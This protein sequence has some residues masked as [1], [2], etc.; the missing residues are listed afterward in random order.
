MFWRNEWFIGIC[1][2]IISGLIVFFIQMVVTSKLGRKDYIKKVSYANEEILSLLK[3]V[4]SEDVYPSI[5]ILDSL[6]SSIS[7]RYN[8]KK[9][10][11]NSETDVLDDLIREVFDTSFMSI[12]KKILSANKIIDLKDQYTIR[13]TSREESPVLASKENLSNKASVESSFVLLTTLVA[14][15]LMGTFLIKDDSLFFGEEI[16]KLTSAMGIAIATLG[17]VL[18]AL[19]YVKSR[20]DEERLKRNIAKIREEQHTKIINKTE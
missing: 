3:S 12:D 13:E 16:T 17:I 11:L 4:I 8:V 5:T 18:G 1:V 15:G 6:I 19:L 10:D 2:G 14:F 7:R 9:S 20:R